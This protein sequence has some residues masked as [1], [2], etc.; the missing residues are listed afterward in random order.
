M[1]FKQKLQ[2]K[3]FKIK[4]KLVAFFALGIGFLT[5]SWGIVGHERINK[6]AVMALPQPLQ[7]FSVFLVRK[8]QSLHAFD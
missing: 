4:P 3:N 8:S 6:A 7:V 1:Y 5:L 2:M